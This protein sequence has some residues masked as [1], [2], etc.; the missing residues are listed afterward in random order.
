MSNKIV[1]ILI[2][3]F[4][5]AAVGLGYAIYKQRSGDTSDLLLQANLPPNELDL[6]IE[7]VPSETKGEFEFV[8]SSQKE[9]TIFVGEHTQIF[10]IAAD[11]PYYGEPPAVTVIGGAGDIQ[12]AKSFEIW[13]DVISVDQ[14]KK[15][16][17]I[18]SDYPRPISTAF[19]PRGPKIS[20]Q[21]IKKGDRVVASSE[22]DAKGEPDYG[23]I[24]FIQ[25]TPSVE[26]I[27]QLR[28]AQ[29][30]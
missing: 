25:I 24:K 7:D 14:N 17:R 13:G 22:Y 23:S 29:G 2:I 9:F 20:L 21:D 6:P 3:V 12:P 18:S 19:T 27:K 15:A 1:T 8:D 28:E 5:L 11:S 4:A 16:I 26:E 30:K 10:G